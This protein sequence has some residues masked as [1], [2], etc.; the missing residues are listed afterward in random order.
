[1]KLKEYILTKKEDIRDITVKERLRS[2]QLNRNFVISVVG[3]RRA[4]KT[5]FI[6][7][8]IKSNELRDDE[9][10]FVNFEDPVEVK[11]PEKLPIV[12]QEIYGKLPE[13]IFLDE[14]QALDNWIKT[15]YFLYESK[16]YYIFITG[17]SS[18]LLSQEIATQLRGRSITVKILPFSLKEILLMRGMGIK[19]HYSSYEIG[20]IKNELRRYMEHGAFPDV[21]LGNI[22]PSTFYRDYLDIVTYRDIIERYGIENRYALSL[23]MKAVVSSFAKNFSVNKVFNTLKS[24]GVGVSRKTLYNFQKI[25]E[26]VG[27][28]FF[29]R[30]YDKSV[31]KVEMTLPKVYLVDNGIYRFM[32]GKKDYGR[33]LE[34]LVFQELVKS[35]LEPN[36]EI[37]YWERGGKEVDFVIKKDDKVKQLI[38]VTCASSR[39]EI[40][41]REIESLIKAGR[42]LKCDDLLIITWDYEDQFEVSGWR[43][44]FL[45]LWKWALGLIPV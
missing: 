26:D 10:L 18:K 5:Y 1:M 40:E 43:V 17:S 9:Y 39:E 24:I 2:I 8:F 41:E 34:G 36:R 30:K 25:L 20:A 37:F 44:R 16:R 19:K 4:G 22:H 6:Y 27:L 32:E 11:E 29:L 33:L 3:P 13:F 45:P 15:V 7:H 12:H 21:V 28:V 35:G 42:E 23:F 14:I 31:R 38:Q